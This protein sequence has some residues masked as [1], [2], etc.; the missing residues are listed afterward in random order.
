MRKFLSS[1]PLLA[2]VSIIGCTTTAGYKS[3]EAYYPLKEGMKWVYKQEIFK[4]GELF[5]DG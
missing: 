4:N 1:I 5:K 3:I 2:L